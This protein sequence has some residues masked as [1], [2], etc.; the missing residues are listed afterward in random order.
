[1][2]IREQIN[3]KPAIVT[4]ATA[5][6]L[7]LA[8]LWM[9]FQLGFFG[10]PSAPASAYFWL[11]DNRFVIGDM[12]SYYESDPLDPSR[13]VI[14]Y[15]VKP[16]GG[17]ELVL[18]YLQRLTTEQGN[19]VAAEIRTPTMSRWVSINSPEAAEIRRNVPL[20]GDGQ[21]MVPHQP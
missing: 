2:G 3:E 21:V 7:F 14:A 10:K 20:D 13:P 6:I 4:A 5:G 17:G 18:W 1:M 9:S 19:G 8:L 16:S 12:R 15:R 11:G